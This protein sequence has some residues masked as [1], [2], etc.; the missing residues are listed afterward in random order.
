MS[1]WP[2]GLGI[3][4][5]SAGLLASAQQPTPF[6]VNAS[7]VVVPV[8]AVDK[9]GATVPAL[10]QSDFQIFEDG[11]PVEIQTFLAPSGTA[12]TGEDGRFIVIAL[13][14]L[15]TP[16]EIAFRVKGIAKRFVDK[17]GPAD[18]ISVISI[19]GGKAVTT[20][21]KEEL[22][23]AINRFTPMIGDDTMT[24]AQKA[25]H[26]LKMIGSLSDQVAKSPHRR[27]LIVFIG[28]AHMFNP[29]EPSAFSDRDNDLSPEWAE[30]VRTTSRNNVSVYAIDPEGLGGTI[31]DW[32]QSFSAE[33]GGYTWSRTNN[34]ANAVDRIWQ[35][36]ASYYLLGYAAPINDQRIH[37]I[38]VKISKPGVTI[39]ARKARG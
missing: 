34:Y 6:S 4:L 30:A 20:S 16:A 2:K 18:V 31:A 12:V 27:K 14:N 23:A 29:S 33:T 36:S 13:D 28:N 15:F 25:E 35:E 37:K 24:G 1:F 7:L 32:S 9:K 11:K 10:T 5:L 8:V 17:M 3:V 19:N 22:H 39:R 26:G 21:L 38:E